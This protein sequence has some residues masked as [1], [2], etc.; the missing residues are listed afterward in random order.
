MSL[1]AFNRR[2]RVIAKTEIEPEEKK[3][4][5]NTDTKK[6]E[7]VE[8]KEPIKEEEKTVSKESVKLIKETAKPK[9]RGRP[10]KRDDE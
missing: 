2:R 6:K 7:P 5:L 10:P 3:S 9:R 1:T 4:L 8:K